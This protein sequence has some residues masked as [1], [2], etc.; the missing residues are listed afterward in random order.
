MGTV[1]LIDAIPEAT[2]SLESRHGSRIAIVG[3]GMLG[4]ILA[5]RYGQTG[6]TVT[7]FEATERPERRGHVSV[8]SGDRQLV[9]ML[10]ELDLSQKVRWGN[11]PLFGQRFGALDGGP[12]RIIEA[13]RSRA[14]AIDVDVRLGTPVR[15][16]Y[17]DGDGFAVDTD[18]ETGAFDQVVVTVPS[19]MA[20]KIIPALPTSERTALANA[21]YVGI[22]NVSFVLERPLRQR[23]ITRVARG[24]D[25]FTLIDPSA[26]S[27]DGAGHHV[28]YV[29]RPVAAADDLFEAGDREIIEHFARALP[30]N[31]HIMSARVSRVPHAFAHHQFGSFSSSIPNL[32]IVNAA[33]MSTGRHHLERTAS[34]ATSVF[35]TLCAEQ[36]T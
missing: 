6:R 5:L 12:G 8:A 7:M 2:R 17:K 33:H 27:S 1:S 19:P 26:L 20:S 13:L 24:R 36:F 25:P 23:Y 32:S 21:S 4:T 16:I 15:A 31:A 10:D 11:A 30:G 22:L 3:G 35:R 34:L 14:R 18:G 9:R 28:V 29:S